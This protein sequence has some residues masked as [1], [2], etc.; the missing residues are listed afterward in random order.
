MVKPQPVSPESMLVGNI[1]D[2]RKVKAKASFEHLN[3][4]TILRCQQQQVDDQC[5]SPERTSK[6]MMP[7]T[8]ISPGVTPHVNR[9]VSPPSL[10]TPGDHQQWSR[11][12]KIM[13][14]TS[15]CPASCQR[16]PSRA[17]CWFPW[18]G[19]PS[20]KGCKSPMPPSNVSTLGRSHSGLRLVK[21]VMNVLCH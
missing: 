18:Q 12:S 2:S 20:C 1:L 3:T 15:W 16:R 6:V 10:A 9:R 5:E 4:H 13:K 8:P 17:A 11:I 14:S 7:A 21:N 19:A